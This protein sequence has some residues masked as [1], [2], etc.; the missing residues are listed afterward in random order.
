MT[1]EDND[2]IKIIKGRRAIRDYDT[3]KGLPDEILYRIIEAGTY[4]P[5]AENQQ[6][7]RLIIV[8]AP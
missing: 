3:E 5:S 7:W 1:L 8:R 4:A 2:T 6:P